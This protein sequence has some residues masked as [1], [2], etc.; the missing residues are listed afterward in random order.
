MD[1]IMVAWPDIL[2][3]KLSLSP[4]GLDFK[5]PHLCLMALSVIGPTIDTWDKIVL[6]DSFSSILNAEL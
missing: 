6:W 4:V 2:F 3:W 1:N 5:E